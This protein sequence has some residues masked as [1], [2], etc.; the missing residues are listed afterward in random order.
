MKFISYICIFG[1]L[2]SGCS[3]FEKKCYTDQP[4]D[5]TNTAIVGIYLDK[6]GYP[7]ANVEQ[8]NVHPGQRVLFAGP[9]RFDIFFKDQR[10]PNGQI[11]FKSINGVA[12]VD[13][14]RDIFDRGART[15]AVSTRELL[16]RYGI[17]ANDKET[18][19]TIRITPS[20]Q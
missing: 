5:G 13:I 19:P 1:L 15:A 16:Y 14:P 17:R 3:H 7:Q 8:V 18:D 2:F 6:N 4:L 12:V 10:S 20:S 9:D 11:E